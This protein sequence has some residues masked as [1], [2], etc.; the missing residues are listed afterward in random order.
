MTGIT[1]TVRQPGPTVARVSVKPEPE[2]DWPSLSPTRR[3]RVVETQAAARPGP[4]PEDS[5]R[6]KS[7]GCTRTPEPGVATC[8]LRPGVTVGGRVIPSQP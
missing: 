6:N 5:G 7:H 8:G 2:S 3:S 4:E 1:A